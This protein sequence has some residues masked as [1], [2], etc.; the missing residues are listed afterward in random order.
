MSRFD[1]LQIGLKIL[2]LPNPFY[3]S[4][5]THLPQQAGALDPHLQIQMLEPEFTLTYPLL[6]VVVDFRSLK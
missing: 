5:H 1:M 6:L 4:F 3:G 2:A